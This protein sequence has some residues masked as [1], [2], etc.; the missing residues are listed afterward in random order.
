MTTYNDSLAPQ[1]YV[2]PAKPVEKTA[3]EL[4]TQYA[5]AA[6][7]LVK[8]E[9]AKSSIPVAYGVLASKVREKFPLTKEQCYL[10]VEA[11][12]KEWHADKF[13]AKEVGDVEG[14]VIK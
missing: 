6:R 12:D 9:M 14:E 7:N 5:T 2:A 1:N 11:V 13:E 3:E 4:Y 8:S 10:V